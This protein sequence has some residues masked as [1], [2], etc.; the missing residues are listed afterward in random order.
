MP[1]KAEVLPFGHP[2]AVGDQHFVRDVFEKH[3]EALRRF[4]LR[5]GVSEQNSQD[6]AQDVYLRLTRQNDP[7]K[8]RDAPR[9]YLYTIATNLV[10]DQIRK[11]RREAEERGSLEE[12]AIQPDDINT[13]DQ[14]A[15]VYR[16]L[17]HLKTALLEL[18]PNKQKILLLNRFHGLSCRQIAEQTGIPFRTVQR[19]LNE[20][21]LYCKSKMRHYRE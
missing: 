20:A 6:I 4:I 12:E 17:E 5:L 15:D 3:H 13:P 16:K 9:A 1:R 8:L 21:L 11:S 18:P 10:R 19:Y 14:E 7:E 2:G